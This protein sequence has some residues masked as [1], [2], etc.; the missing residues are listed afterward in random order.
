VGPTH[1]QGRIILEGAGSVNPG[2]AR[3][4][5]G[6][7]A[8]GTQPFNTTCE[9]KHDLYGNGE[10]YQQQA[11]RLWLGYRVVV[12][13]Q[14]DGFMHDERAIARSTRALAARDGL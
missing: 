13:F 2:L 14:E 3:R 1:A 6:V 7:P 8:E 10:K 12:A 11:M 5:A 4:Y 9:H